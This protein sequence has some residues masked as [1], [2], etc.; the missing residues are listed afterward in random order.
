M[1]ATHHPNRPAGVSSGP[2]AQVPGR[3]GQGHLSDIREEGSE[4]A[5]IARRGPQSLCK[6]SK[7][8]LD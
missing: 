7:V 3:S 4:R 5:K 6:K 1:I 2:S 8:A